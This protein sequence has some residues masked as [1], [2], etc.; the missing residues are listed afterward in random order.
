MGRRRSSLNDLVD[1]LMLFPWWVS[2]A[3]APISYLFLTQYLA[4]IELTNVFIQMF[5]RA[6]AHIAPYIAAGFAAIA[7]VIL[8]KNWHRRR[9]LDQQSGI[10]SIRELSWEEFE[11]L[12]GEVFRRQGYQVVETGR[13]PDDGIDL[14]LTQGGKKS[15]VQCKHWKQR[16]VSVVPVR[17]LLGAIYAKGANTG[18][19]VCSGDYTQP[20]RTFAKENG[21]RLIDG[22]E[23]V[24]LIRAVQ[25]TTS[26]V[27]QVGVTAPVVM[28][29]SATVPSVTVEPSCPKCGSAMVKR[30]AKQGGN[31]GQAFWGCTTFPRCRGVVPISGRE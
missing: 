4:H 13:G 24:E 18:I 22:G 28:A 26:E 9:L 10:E 11:W 29:V 7:V 31:Q 16:K 5:L 2:A 27:R 17:E 23:L 19:F 6:I 30:V 15:L 3:L 21:I 14:V 20:A 1:L 25:R 12:I 8:F